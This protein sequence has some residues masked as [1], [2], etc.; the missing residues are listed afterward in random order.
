[1]GEGQLSLIFEKR[2]TSH[3]TIEFN[4]ILTIVSVAALSLIHI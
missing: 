1:M 3:V 2:R 4:Q